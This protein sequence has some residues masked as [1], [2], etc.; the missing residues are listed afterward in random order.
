MTWTI[1]FTKMIPI[2]IFFSLS[3]VFGNSAY[4]YLSVSYIQMLKSF[5]PVPTLLAAFLVG[6]ETPSTFQLILV[7]IISFGVSMASIGE[8]NLSIP[9]FL[10]QVIIRHPFIHSLFR[11]DFLV[12]TSKFNVL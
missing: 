8:H 6:K 9:G 2:S 5:T 12:I 4:E 3:L 11:F 1:Y 7:V 10:L